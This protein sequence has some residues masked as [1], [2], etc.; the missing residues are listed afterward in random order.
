VLH[1]VKLVM[2][3]GISL[4]GNLQSK[5]LEARPD[6]LSVA[7]S[8]FNLHFQFSEDFDEH[9]SAAQAIA[10]RMHG[11]RLLNSW[12]N[13]VKPSKTPEWTSIKQAPVRR[14]PMPRHRNG[15]GRCQGPQQN[16]SPMTTEEREAQIRLFSCLASEHNRS[17]DCGYL[18]SQGQ[19]YAHK[20]QC[21]HKRNDFCCRM[22]Q[23][24]PQVKRGEDPYKS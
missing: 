23:V 2:T 11:E 1:S 8:Q 18:V 4:V 14:G 17:V 7:A 6:I 22:G 5:L 12:V 16:G 19:L 13:K 9:I 15:V 20:A 10:E 3:L 24:A 21:T